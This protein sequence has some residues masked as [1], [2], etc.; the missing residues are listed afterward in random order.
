MDVTFWL[1]LGIWLNISNPRQLSTL[2][3]VLPCL[4]LGLERIS[5]H[6]FNHP[7]R[8]TNAISNSESLQIALLWYYNCHA[9][10]LQITSPRTGVVL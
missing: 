1:S 8:E 3:V 4:V 10:G 7:N 2:T 5:S 6:R 9:I